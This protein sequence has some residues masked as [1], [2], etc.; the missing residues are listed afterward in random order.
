MGDLKINLL[1]LKFSLIPFD[2]GAGVISLTGVL[3]DC[4][5]KFIPIVSGIPPCSTQDV[6]LR[7][8]PDDSGNGADDV[9]VPSG[10]DTHGVDRRCQRC[11]AR[12]VV[13]KTPWRVAGASG[14]HCFRH[15]VVQRLHLAYGVRLRYLGFD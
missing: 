3:K 15:S 9:E 5:N 11:P 1:R 14:F 8:R 12:R 2:P 13:R 7:V 4:Q 10:M 6:I